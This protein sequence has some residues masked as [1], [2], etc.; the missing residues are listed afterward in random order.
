MH[1]WAKFR[2][3]KGWSQQELAIHLGLNSRG[4]VGDIEREAEQASPFI[5]IK[6]DRLSCGEVPVAVTRPDL[7]DVRVIQPAHS[8]PA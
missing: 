1:P 8:E 2:I 6:M 3:K 4:R 7:H 5:A